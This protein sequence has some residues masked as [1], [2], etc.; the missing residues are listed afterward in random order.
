MTK[1]IEKFFMYVLSFAFF[2]EKYIFIIKKMVHQVKCFSSKSG[3]CISDS[4]NPYTSWVGV[5]A[6]L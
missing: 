6:G 5:V 3:G 2:F 1:Y 4:Q